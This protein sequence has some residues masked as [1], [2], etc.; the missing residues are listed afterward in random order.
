MEII[1]KCNGYRSYRL[2]SCSVASNGETRH[3]DV[4]VREYVSVEPF[5]DLIRITTV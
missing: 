3:A 2:D 1:S 5:S 4:L